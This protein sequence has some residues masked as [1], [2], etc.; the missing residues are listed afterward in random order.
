M[1]RCIR[2]LLHQCIIDDALVQ[3]PYPFILLFL[4]FFF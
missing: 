2:Y 4:I 3:H 1:H